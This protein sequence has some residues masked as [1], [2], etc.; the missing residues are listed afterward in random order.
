[1]TGCWF[2]ALTV[3]GCQGDRLPRHPDTHHPILASATT[4]SIMCLSFLD[5]VYALSEARLMGP[6]ATQPAISPER[7]RVDLAEHLALTEAVLAR[8]GQLA[9]QRL[10]DHFET[11]ASRL[12]F[13]PS[14]RTLLGRSAAVRRNA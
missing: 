10:I 12:G 2:A 11:T 3:S 13:A 1:V 5:A 7:S 9:R 6:D 8:D 14:W 4:S